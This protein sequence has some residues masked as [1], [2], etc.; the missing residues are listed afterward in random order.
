MVAQEFSE[1][2][3]KLAAIFKIDA[4]EAQKLA[5]RFDEPAEVLDSLIDGCRLT[6]CKVLADTSIVGFFMFLRDMIGRAPN[7]A[8]KPPNFK[9]TVTAALRDATQAL[10]A[11]HQEESFDEYSPEDVVEFMQRQATGFAKLMLWAAEELEDVPPKSRQALRYAGLLSADEW[12]GYA[13]GRWKVSCL[14]SELESLC[15]KVVE[16]VCFLCEQC[17]RAACSDLVA[18]RFAAPKLLP[19]IFGGL[20]FAS[21]ARFCS[22]MLRSLFCFCLHCSGHTLKGTDV[23]LFVASYEEVKNNSKAFFEH[24]ESLVSGD[25]L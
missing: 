10:A 1:E 22:H 24:C 25:E 13:E 11:L 20:P 2:V 4:A 21:E 9:L 16:Q 14:D 23:A 17:W 18:L 5:S 6:S 12:K 19:A 7:E 8:E 15:K 3:Q